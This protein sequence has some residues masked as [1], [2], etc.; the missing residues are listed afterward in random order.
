[1]PAQEKVHPESSWWPW[2]IGA[3]LLV[4][5]VALTV[6]YGT[7]V[8]GMG[9]TFDE[10]YIVVP[11]QALLNEGWSVTN[12]IDFKETKGPTFIWAYAIAGEAL[13]ARLNALR[14]V[15]I[16][17]FVLGAAPLLWI[18]RRCGVG[19]PSLLLV[20]AFYVVLPYNAALG[21]L[22]MS[23]PSFVCGSLLLTSLFVWGFGRSGASEVRVLG[24]IAFGLVLSILLHHRIHAVAIAGAACL[25]AF[26]RDGWR[27]W[28]WWLAC[29][30]AGL[31]RV[32]LWI[33]WGG[34]VSPSY[35]SAHGFGFG[36]D[37]LTY[38]AAAVLPV[39]LLFLWPVL[40]ESQYRSRR[41]L[42]WAGGAIGLALG[43]FASP[44]LAERLVLED[45]E[46]RRFLGITATAVSM[47]APS[48]NAQ[49]F[50]FV[51]LSTTGVASLGAMAAIA[52]QRPVTNQQALVTRFLTLTLVTGWAL[53]VPTRSVV[54]DRYVLPWAALVPI[55]W[56]LTFRKPALALQALGLTALFCAYVWKLLIKMP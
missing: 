4:L 13:G 3:L 31:S 9:T 19:G 30:A 21:Q 41:W 56:V 16:L 10:K 48:A 34:L 44:S 5:V 1:M 45:L 42:V 2:S 15:S 43:L 22:V 35:Q 26:E 28:P 6:R 55:V 24:P 37:S 50:V 29:A 27:S 49:W 8:L 54:Y 18:A 17:F 11:I 51:V 12:A 39:T 23:E 7:N 40:T 53:Y 33:R 25:V 47:I 38:L 20:A 32:P 36:P 46:P 52:W 14:L